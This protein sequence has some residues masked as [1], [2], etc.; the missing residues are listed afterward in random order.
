MN[1]FGI[2]ASTTFFLNGILG[3]KPLYNDFYDPNSPTL[4]NSVL[5]AKYQANGGKCLPKDSDDFQMV[6]W[7][8]LQHAS[9][10]LR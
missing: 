6:D 9:V 5:L 3:E 2:P 7:L 4:G 1:D 8:Y 10:D